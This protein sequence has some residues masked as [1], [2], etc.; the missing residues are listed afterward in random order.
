MAELTLDPPVGVGHVTDKNL[1]IKRKHTLVPACMWQHET[2]KDEVLSKD[3][4]YIPDER[5]VGPVTT[6]FPSNTKWTLQSEAHYLGSYTVKKLTQLR[7]H[8]KMQPPP[9]QQAWEARLGI[10]INWQKVWRLK[11]H[12]TT[13][14][15]QVTWLKLIHRN[16][17]VANRDPQCVNKTCNANGC[18][19]DESMMH[20]ALCNVIKTH[21]WNHLETT[22]NNLGLK[23]GTGHVFWITGRITHNTYAD[24]E[25]MGIIFLA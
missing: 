1:P 15:D 14:K 19:Q 9:A 17:Y 7:T 16:L 10:R 24:T 23:H 8:H 18:T 13:P 20:L 25:S 6:A 5:W 11:C 4:E 22:M 3:P 21:F 12:Y 2:E